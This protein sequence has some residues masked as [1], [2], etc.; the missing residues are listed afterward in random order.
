MCVCPTSNFHKAWTRLGPGTLDGACS[1]RVDPEGHT[2]GQRGQST[3]AW[4]EH[5]SSG[6]GP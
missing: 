2:H 1:T 5:E 6:V 4:S 3:L